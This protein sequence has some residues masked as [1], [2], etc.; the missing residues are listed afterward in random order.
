MECNAMQCNIIMQGDLTLGNTPSSVAIAC[1]MMYH[2]RILNGATQILVCRPGALLQEVCSA[3]GG[4][5]RD[6]V[7]S[8]TPRFEESW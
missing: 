3:S 1:N 8:D 6:A 4:F 5:I 7:C 2:E